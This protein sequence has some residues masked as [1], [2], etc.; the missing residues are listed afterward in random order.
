MNMLASSVFTAFLALTMAGYLILGKM[1]L[2][3]LDPH[4]MLTYAAVLILQGVWAVAIRT[5]RLT[6]RLSLI[7]SVPKGELLKSERE[8][9]FH[10][11]EVSGFRREEGA[12]EGQIVFARRLRVGLLLEACSYG[13]LVLML[14]AG[15]VKYGYGMNGAVDLS[16]GAEWTD[17]SSLNI[18]RGFLSSRSEPALML[19]SSSIVSS[20]G[21]SL[22]AID[23]E[24]KEKDSGVTVPVKLS[25]GEEIRVRGFTLRY[26]GD[27]YTAMIKIMRKNHDYMPYPLRVTRGPDATDEWYRGT[28]PIAEPKTRGVGSFDPAQKVFRVTVY[29]EEREEFRAEFRY[30]ETARVGD[31]EVYVPAMLHAGR[32]MVTRHGSRALILAGFVMLAVFCSARFA[33]RPQYVVFW[34]RGDQEY[35]HASGRRLRKLLRQG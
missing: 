10:M 5:M 34:R 29:R 6:S 23:A 2:I 9:A 28:F 35:F 21:K 8:Q 17:V 14:S 15:A 4:I 12:Q 7:G 1:S 25:A 30:G 16:T 24:V 11:L 22:S 26:L 19:R 27:S 3:P 13:A 32:L 33:V 18:E 20:S 31:F